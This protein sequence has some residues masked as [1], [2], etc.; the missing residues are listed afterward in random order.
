MIVTA[1]K[2]RC[3]VGGPLAVTDANVV[4]G[5]IIPCYF[6]QIFGATEDQPIDVAASKRAFE[7]LTN[8]V[9]LCLSYKYDHFNV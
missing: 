3:I 2:R 9:V 4:L 8:E 1:G 7:A 6:P 5:R